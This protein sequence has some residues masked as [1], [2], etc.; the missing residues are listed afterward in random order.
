M[1]YLTQL[2]IF[3]VHEMSDS[4]SQRIIPVRATMAT[5]ALQLYPHTRGIPVERVDV[6]N[7]MSRQHTKYDTKRLHTTAQLMQ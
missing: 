4:D 5:G 2:G 3:R 6:Q 1:A 7:A